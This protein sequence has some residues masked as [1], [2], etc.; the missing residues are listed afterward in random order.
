MTAG[1]ALIIGGVASTAP[2]A[3]AASANDL[4][5][6][7]YFVSPEG[8]PCGNS[9]G[10]NERFY[11]HCT[12]NGNNVQVLARF[13]AYSNKIACVGPNQA[14]GIGWLKSY[15]LDWNGQTCGNPGAVWEA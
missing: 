2:S 13:I 12:G 1:A 9:V 15:S 5:S 14:V 4:R 6:G 8:L 7:V 3:A 11:K 10:G